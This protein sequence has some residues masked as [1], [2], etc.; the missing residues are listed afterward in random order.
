M[1][2][3]AFIHAMEYLLELRHDWEAWI[4]H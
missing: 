4:R 1:K 2:R 3:I